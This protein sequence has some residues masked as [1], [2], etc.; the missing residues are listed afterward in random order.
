MSIFGKKKKTGIAF[1]GGATRGLAHIGV[2]KVLEEHGLKFDIVAGNSAG[3]IV[4]AF[5]AAG[6]SWKQLYDIAKSITPRELLGL[7]LK[8]RGLFNSD[9]LE[10]FLKQHL[11]ETNIE[12]LEIPFRCV[13]VNL[14]NGDLVE[15][16]HGP[17]V[18][19]VRASCSM[20][21]VFSP[22]PLGDMLLVDGGIKNSV[23]GDVIKDMGADFAV[24]V[25][26]NADRGELSP[27]KNGFDVIWSSLKIAWNENTVQRLKD[28]DVVIAPNL[29][30]FTYY[31]LK[32]IDALVERGERAMREQIEDV[33]RGFG[34]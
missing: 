25:N 2:I 13:A 29:K 34:R 21:G 26:L 24:A 1:G 16:S 3:S 15:L 27:P 23:P 31:D 4:G 32:H 6:F 10:A 5:Y 22:T 28:V 12:E 14:Y 11:G 7:N 8:R 20:P 30:D 19:A 9:K 18:R 17:L 33:L